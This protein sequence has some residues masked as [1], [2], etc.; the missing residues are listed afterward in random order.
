MGVATR[1]DPFRDLE[2]LFTQTVSGRAGT[3]MPMDLFRTGDHYVIKVDLPGADPGSIDVSV[4]DRMLT[5]RGQ[6]STAD[7]TDVQWLVQERASGTFARQ[8]ALGRGI[9][10]DSIAATYAE[11]V[12]TLSIPVTPE[13]QPRRIEVSTGASGGSGDG[14]AAADQV[15]SHRAAEPQQI[16]SR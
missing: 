13:V 3:A 5:I 14:A 1:L 12:L 6:R 15:E 11:G 16:D 4:D 9:S 8:I 7:D 10:T 2:R